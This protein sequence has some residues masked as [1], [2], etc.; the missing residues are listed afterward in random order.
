MG[1]S[2]YAGIDMEQIK[3]KKRALLNRG[4]LRDIIFVISVASSLVWGIDTAR[5]CIS[6]L[7]LFLGCALHFI[8]KGILIRNVV[9]CKDG[10]YGI[11]RHPYYLANYLIDSSFCLL[12]GNIYLLLI[13]PFLFFWA[14][15]PTL[16]KEEETLVSTHGAAYAQYSSEV[17]Q[18]F[19]HGQSIKTWKN[20]VRGFSKNRITAKEMSRLTRFWGMAI[21]LMLVHDLREEGLKELMS[22][23][24][25]RDLDG[26]LYLGLSVCLFIASFFILRK[27]KR[28]A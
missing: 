12:S 25:P 21:F 1:R 23:S 5:L 20:I 19:P 14:Y 24:Y 6:L 27:S 10:T 15:G 9:L 22:F 16:R 2:I 11:V 13:Y 4:N 26:L 28:R 18:V 17:P 7:L 8:T 3:K